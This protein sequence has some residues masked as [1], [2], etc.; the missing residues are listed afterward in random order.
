M[1]GQIC[2]TADLYVDRAVTCVVYVS[3]K[4]D[5]IVDV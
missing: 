5:Q 2:V 3:P 4:S 1:M